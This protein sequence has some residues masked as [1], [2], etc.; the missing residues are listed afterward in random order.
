MVT[1]LLKR[2]L[3]EFP[4]AKTQV[5]AWL[6]AG[7]GMG[8]YLEP[9]MKISQKLVVVDISREVL[10][11][12]DR[13]L[14]PE[15]VQRIDRVCASLTA[16][17]FADN[18]FS[19][20]T[21]LDVVEHIQED[22]QAV[23]EILR[24]LTPEGVGILAVPAYPWL[25]SEFDRK[26]QHVRRYTRRSFRAMLEKAGA[27]VLYTSYLFAGL[28]PIL[29]IHRKILM[30][31]RGNRWRIYE[32]GMLEEI[33]LPPGWINQIAS[34]YFQGEVWM[35]LHRGLPMGSSVFAVIRKK[36]R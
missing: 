1:G 13:T 19:V 16:L 28:V 32:E 14:P 24:V 7:P 2:F 34:V 26:V 17:P 9:W 29:I 15:V 11:N 18:T 21:A 33:H 10:D 36:M 22:V 20:V 23:R 5:P 6:D 35:A 4:G 31:L 12:L 25:W 8:V 3:P 30:P 27:D